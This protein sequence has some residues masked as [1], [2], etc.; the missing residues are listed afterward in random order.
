MEAARDH[1]PQLPES[2]STVRR[3]VLFQQPRHLPLEQELEVADNVLALMI[4]MHTLS[5]IQNTR[6]LAPTHAQICTCTNTSTGAL[7]A[8]HRWRF[9]WAPCSTSKGHLWLLW[10]LTNHDAQRSFVTT[11][12]EQKNQ[13]E[14]EV[15]KHKAFNK[16]F[17]SCWI[18]YKGFGF[19]FLFL[20]LHKWQNKMKGNSWV[21][22][23]TQWWRNNMGCLSRNGLTWLYSQHVRASEG[24]HAPWQY[25]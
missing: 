16:T 20:L 2:L 6:W 12:A 17:F 4:C 7:S 24:I 5:P 3:T 10:W 13:H 1:L 14:R 22:G 19:S 18:H 9:M 23:L 11:K 8:L 15:N 21:R 25:I